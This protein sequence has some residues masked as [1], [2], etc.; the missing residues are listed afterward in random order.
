MSRYSARDKA[1]NPKLQ[2]AIEHSRRRKPRCASTDLD[3]N[4]E[5][6][7]AYDEN[8]DRIFRKKKGRKA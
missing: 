7:R 1:D 2:S 6:K 4:P 8:Y 5:A 3:H